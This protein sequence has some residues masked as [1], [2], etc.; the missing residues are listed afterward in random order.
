MTPICLLV[1]L[2]LT[3]VNILGMSC[4]LYMLMWFSIARS[5][6]K[7][8]YEAFSITRLLGHTKECPYIILYREKPF[9]V[10]F[11]DVTII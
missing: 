9:V 7:I 3:L 1:C 5:L 6:L 2:S 8:K 11:K 10:N 4:D